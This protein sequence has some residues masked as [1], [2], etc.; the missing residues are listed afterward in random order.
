MHCRTARR[1]GSL[2]GIADAAARPARVI[3][4]RDLEGSSAEEV[5]AA[6]DVSDGNQRVLLHRARSRVRAALEAHL[7]GVSPHDIT[8]Q[9]IVELVTDYLEHALDGGAGRALRAAHQLLRRLRV[10]PRS[11][12]RHD[13]DG[14]Q[15]CEEEDVPPETRDALLGA[16]RDW[17]KR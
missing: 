3:R 14:R 10:L 7:D 11:D 12:A 9:E 1:C 4:M 6:L 15:R 5:C 16:F 17:K 2:R 13:R 8:C